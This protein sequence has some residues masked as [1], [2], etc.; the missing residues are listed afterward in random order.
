MF[1]EWIVHLRH[2]FFPPL[3]NGLFFF[4]FSPSFNSGRLLVARKDSQ[5]VHKWPGFSSLGHFPPTRY[6]RLSLSFSLQA[7]LSVSS[8]P[9]FAFSLFSL[10]EKKKRKVGFRRVPSSLT[11]NFAYMHTQSAKGPL[12]QTSFLF[13]SSACSHTPP[14]SD[15]NTH[16]LRRPAFLSL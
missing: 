1:R 2:F 6:T 11:R 16:T 4:F 9:F 7:V 14:L 8:S 5:S 12:I 10:K 3:G 13:F 15:A